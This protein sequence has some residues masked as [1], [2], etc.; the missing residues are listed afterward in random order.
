MGS[1][2]E[3]TIAYNEL[4]SGVFDLCRAAEDLTSAVVMEFGRPNAIVTLVGM[5]D[6][7]ASIYFSSGGGILGTGSDENVRQIAQEFADAGNAVLRSENI[8]SSHPV[9]V[10]AH[11]RFYLVAANV[12]KT[13]EAE[14]NE[15]GNNLHRCSSL[16]HKGHE[17][18]DAIRR[19]E[20]N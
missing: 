14:E 13:V 12:V 8:V 18:I 19:T 1:V 7:T 3:S 9:P 16:F 2:N 10:T 15:L 6:G 17:L 5:S 4:R 11:V 20:N